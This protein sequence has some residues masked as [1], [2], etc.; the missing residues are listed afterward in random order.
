MTPMASVVILGEVAHPLELDLRGL[1]RLAASLP[2]RPVRLAAGRDLP[3]LR[4]DA[5]LARA[6][7]T[8]RACSLVAESEDGQMTLTVP[9]AA[10]KLSVLL[11]RVGN[12][13]LPRGLGGPVR[14]VVPGHGEVK[15]LATLYVCDNAFERDDDDAE[16]QPISIFR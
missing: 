9:I 13:P 12:K 15:A 16:T 2:S 8:D 6:G 3:G 7:L 4:L 5:L 10:I 14:L 1:D 11:F